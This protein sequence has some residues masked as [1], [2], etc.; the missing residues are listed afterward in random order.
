MRKFNG[1]DLSHTEKLVMTDGDCSAFRGTLSWNGDSPLTQYFSTAGALERR[2]FRS[3]P[4]HLRLEVLANLRV[5]GQ[6][7]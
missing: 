2:A 6:A 5:M 3:L 1:G 4:E 7:A